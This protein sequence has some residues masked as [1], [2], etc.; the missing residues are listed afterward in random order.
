M[1]LAPTKV[2][3]HPKLR[4]LFRKHRYKILYGGR[5]S[6]K[7]WA[8]ARALLLLGA[9]NK[10]F[11]LCAREVQKSI[12]NS[13]H[14]LLS[15]QI[16]L[17][18]LSSFYEVLE[19]EIKGANGTEFQ[20]T[21]L[22]QHTVDS[23]KSFEG[24]DICWVE[25]GQTVVK[26]SWEVLGPTIRKPGS[27]IWVTFN[28][29]METDETY[30]RFV[31]DPPADSF[32]QLINYTDNIYFSA[33]AEGERQE[34]L[35][36]HPK[37][38]PNI[39]EGKCKVT[40]AGAIYAEEVEQCVMENRI[41]M[42][43]YDPA[44]K[45]HVVFD[46]GWNDCMAIALVQ[47]HYSGIRIIDYIED[48]HKTLDHYSALLRENK[49]NWGV[50][51][52]PHDGAHGDHK[53]GKTSQEIMEEKGWTVEITKNLSIEGGI[54]L[55]REVFHQFVFDKDKTARL[56]QCLKRYKRTVH[57]TTQQPGAPLHDEFSHGADCFR[58]I[59]INAE[60]MTNES[61]GSSYGRTPQRYGDDTVGY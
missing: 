48:S 55:A 20:F 21:G 50:V 2:K 7:S 5:S 8:V 42:L 24:A 33:E 35:K 51:Y 29:D 32:V 45:V 53:Y 59:A 9:Q 6:G 37:D 4:G 57:Q 27:E 52:L 30:V 61:Y 3:F 46:L 43:P 25:E 26:K 16:V 17:L 13:V 28:P 31:T 12:K 39:W 15:D 47:K 56:V 36:K 58:Y 11:I 38:Y 10:L 60:Q 41:T 14:K 49:Y 44:L 1:I 34:C 19:T 18:G 40:A 54:K 23:V 22:A